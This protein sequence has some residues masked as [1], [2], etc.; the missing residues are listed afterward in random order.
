MFEKTTIVDETLKL[1]KK[2]LKPSGYACLA[3]YLP[4]EQISV[5]EYCLKEAGLRIVKTENISASLSNAIK[6]QAKNESE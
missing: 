5:F 2:S 1:I 6:I 3:E 4:V